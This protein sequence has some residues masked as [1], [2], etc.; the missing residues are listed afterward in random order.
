MIDSTKLTKITT[1]DFEAG[2]TILVNKPVG[3]T[4][5]DVVNKIKKA[6]RIKKVGHT[7][8]LDPFA[9]GLLILVT[10][11]ATRE[12]AK[13]QNLPKTYEGT[14]VLGRTTDTLDVE[15]Q[16]I[17]TKEVPLLTSEE[18][19]SVLAGFLG[20]S[21][22]VPPAFSALKIGGKRAYHL[23]RK[24]KDVPLEPRPIHIYEIALLNLGENELTFR[25][26]CSKGTYVR[27]LAR[28]VAKALGT[29][30]YLK[31]LTRTQIGPYS[32]KT[33]VEVDAFIDWAKELEKR[34]QP[35][36]QKDG[37]QGIH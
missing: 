36:G 6:L 4:S 35:S 8:T 27:A 24:K 30:G 32:L 1:I 5:F 25:V 18:V 33:A 19:S 37:R 34:K 28:D 23:A 3:W 21:L 10:G 15:G 14:I 31:S 13:F 12:A 9:S 20:E 17:E 29:V 2:E 22:Q 26:T 7:G 16:F 11:R